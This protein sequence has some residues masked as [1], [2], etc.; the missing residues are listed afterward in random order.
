MS[1]NSFIWTFSQSS[2][3]IIP[4]ALRARSL[5][6]ILCGLRK[7]SQL[8][9]VSSFSL[10]RRYSNSLTSYVFNI[11]SVRLPQ[12]PVTCQPSRTF[13]GYA[14][15]Y[16]EVI[17]AFAAFQDTNFSGRMTQCNYFDSAFMIA[18][19]CEAYSQ[20]SSLLESGMDTASQSLP[21]RLELNFNTAT[22]ASFRRTSVASNAGA[23]GFQVGQKIAN[24][25]T[26]DATP[27]ADT[28]RA[29]IYGMVDVIYS[30]TADGLMT[31]SD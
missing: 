18:V 7:Q 22:D 5:K 2:Q 6:T 17:K 30:I 13:Q 9:N 26:V 1:Y 21:V 16:A 11:G 31:A 10:S 14:E 25:N 4:I 19:D 12:A 28:W 27:T 3:E 29:D 24:A 23:V 15:A 20:D 8:N